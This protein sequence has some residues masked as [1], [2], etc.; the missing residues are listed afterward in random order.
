[1]NYAVVILTFV[2]IVATAYWFI[3]GRHFYTGPRTHAHVADGEI[4]EDASDSANDQEK[5]L[6]VPAE[7]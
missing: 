2:L 1:M 5:S 6:R 7:N 3:H 4:I